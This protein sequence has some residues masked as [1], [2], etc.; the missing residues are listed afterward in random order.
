MRASA[1]HDWPCLR[2]AHTDDGSNSVRKSTMRASASHDWPC[3]RNRLAK[4][5]NGSRSL[6]DRNCSLIPH[7]SEGP[8][9]GCVFGRLCLCLCLRT[10]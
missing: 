4:D 9:L 3:L 6:T 8:T 5:S 7:T 2:M 1:S 10:G